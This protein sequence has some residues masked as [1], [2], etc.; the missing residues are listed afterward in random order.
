VEKTTLQI[1]GLESRLFGLT[2]SDVLKL[3]FEMAEK[4]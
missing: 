3:A 2:A 4:K 1:L